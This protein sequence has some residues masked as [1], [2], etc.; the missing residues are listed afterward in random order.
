MV[1]FISFL[2]VIIGA[3]NWFCI[4]ALQYDF[5]AG[6]FGS[7]A[8]ILSRI[9]YFFVGLA[10]IYLTFLAFRDKGEVKVFNFKKKE[11]DP[12]AEEKALPK[13]EEPTLK[14][15]EGLKSQEYKDFNEEDLD[16]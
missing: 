3:L 12:L 11:K 13:K 4:G 5:I 9:I 6:I 1:A 2:L 8:S 14:M 15:A 10:G 16:I 7:Q